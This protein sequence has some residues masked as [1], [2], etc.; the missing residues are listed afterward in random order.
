MVGE[1]PRRPGDACGRD[2]RGE[3]HRRAAPGRRGQDDPP[4]ALTLL[5]LSAVT[6]NRASP[7]V[8]ESVPDLVVVDGN[9][10]EVRGY[11]V[12]GLR[13]RGFDAERLAAVKR[14]HRLLY[15]TGLTFEESREAIAA[16]AAEM[17]HAAG[18][19]ALMIEFL[20][21]ATRGIAR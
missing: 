15:R 1:N 5:A 2:P 16:L 14:M 4:A 3:R 12:V 9:P 6:V 21:N 8:C 10:L 7:G 18:D 20:G 17:P 11:N 19:V 13:R